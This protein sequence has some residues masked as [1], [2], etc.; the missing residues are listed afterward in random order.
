Y[1]GQHT[2]QNVINYTN[3]SGDSGGPVFYVENFTTGSVWL[4]GF[5]HSKKA[6]YSPLTQVARD[7]PGL[8]YR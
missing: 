7:L 5:H 8:S 4:L 2:S 6:V 1:M 3:D